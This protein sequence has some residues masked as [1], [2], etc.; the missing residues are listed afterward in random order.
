MRW[1]LN[2]MPHVSLDDRN[3]GSLSPLTATP[4][5]YPNAG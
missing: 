1:E 5:R 3:W 4:T 2:R